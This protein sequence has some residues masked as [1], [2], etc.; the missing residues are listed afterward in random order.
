MNK[1]RIYTDEKV[2]VWQR[3]G[4][5]IEAETERELTEILNEPDLF[6]AAMNE[7]RIDYN[8]DVQPYWET[9]DHAGWDHDNTDITPINEKEAIL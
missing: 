9:E 2:T 5:V 3:V 6:Q 4:L 1:Y 7:G 8:G